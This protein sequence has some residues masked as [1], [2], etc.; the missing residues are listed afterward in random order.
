M[1]EGV[2]TSFIRDRGFVDQSIGRSLSLGACGH[3]H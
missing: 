1:E 2:V 3:A